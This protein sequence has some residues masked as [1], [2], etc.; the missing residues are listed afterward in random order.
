MGGFPS[1]Y[2]QNAARH[3]ELAQSMLLCLPPR[4][5]HIPDSVLQ[6][7]KMGVSQHHASFLTQ[8]QS[9]IQQDSSLQKLQKKGHVPAAS[10]STLIPASRPADFDRLLN[11]KA[12]PRLWPKSV[13]AVQSLRGSAGSE[14]SHSLQDMQR[15]EG[16]HLRLQLTP[17]KHLPSTSFSKGEGFSSNLS[18]ELHSERLSRARKFTA[19]PSSYSLQ[20]KIVHPC[21]KHENHELQLAL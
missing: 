12:L 18:P 1:P 4:S 10:A 19:E 6:D 17:Q 14:G 13:A 9:T 7:Q 3:N 2:R 20:V 15:G 21:D 8:K 11:S 5:S 16:Q